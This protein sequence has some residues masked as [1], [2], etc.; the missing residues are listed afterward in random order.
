MWKVHLIITAY[1]ISPVVFVLHYGMYF[2]FYIWQAHINIDTFLCGTDE[3]F[4][5][6]TNNTVVVIILK[7]RLFPVPYA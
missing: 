3:T 7:E 5:Q 4:I 2:K 6:Y 1:S